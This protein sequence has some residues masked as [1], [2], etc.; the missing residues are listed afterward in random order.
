MTTI[1]SVLN[2]VLTD[3][4]VYLGVTHF[5]FVDQTPLRATEGLVAPRE[6]GLETRRVGLASPRPAIHFEVSQ[7]HGEEA[8]LRI[9]FGTRKET[10]AVTDDASTKKEVIKHK[11]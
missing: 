7:A 4:F 2:L 10:F 11:R 3:A 9:V 8:S 6:A 1:A 5:A